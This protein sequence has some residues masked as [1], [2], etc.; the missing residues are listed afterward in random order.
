MDIM[1][2]LSAG[3]G[4]DYSSRNVT[5]ITDLYWLSGESPKRAA[6]VAAND[7]APPAAPLP[8][9]CSAGWRVPDCPAL[10][11]DPVPECK[12]P[13]A[14]SAMCCTVWHGSTAGRT[15][16]HSYIPY[17]NRASVLTCTASGV[18]VGSG[19]CVER[20]GAVMPSSVS[21]VVL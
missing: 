7:S 12:P 5:T 4:Y 1:Q 8:L 19:I 20:P 2:R 16:A 11:I 10:T 13:L 9:D 14:W 3:K 17:Y 18:A 6:A 21:Q 15:P